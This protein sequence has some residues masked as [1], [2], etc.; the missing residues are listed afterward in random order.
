MF[1]LGGDFLG[2]LELFLRFFFHFSDVSFFY[3]C[4]IP[5]RAGYDCT[6]WEGDTSSASG[7]VMGGQNIDKNRLV[8][9]TL[10]E[11]KE[12]RNWGVQLSIE[13][14]AIQKEEKELGKK[15]G[16]FNSLKTQLLDVTGRLEMYKQ[17]GWW[18][19]VEGWRCI[20]R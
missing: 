10:K 15:W 2:F 7:L 5:A 11:M 20:N 13:W 17:V 6:T 8:F 1:F 3:P 16:E 12:L 14:D 4:F 9:D 19:I 18:I